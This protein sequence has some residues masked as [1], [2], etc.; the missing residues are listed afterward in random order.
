M[1]RIIVA[2]LA[3]LMAVGAMAQE[4]NPIPLRWKWLDADDVLVNASNGRRIKVINPCK[5]YILKC[6]SLYNAEKI[7]FYK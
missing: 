5:A 6:K 7:R 1:K 4:F 2:A 3:A